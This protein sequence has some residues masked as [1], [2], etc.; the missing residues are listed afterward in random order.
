[1]ASL[2]GDYNQTNNTTQVR[3]VKKNTPLCSNDAMYLKKK[4]KALFCRFIS[5]DT[6]QRNK[7]AQQ[8]VPSFSSLQKYFTSAT[9][10]VLF[11][12]HKQNLTYWNLLEQNL[13]WTKVKTVTI[14]TKIFVLR[15]FFSKIFYQNVKFLNVT[16]KDKWKIVRNYDNLNV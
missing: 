12:F 8:N 13:L 9:K 10:S 3:E 16:K 6:K 4:I 7:S 15:L 5:A 14:A 2:G 1:M 11:L